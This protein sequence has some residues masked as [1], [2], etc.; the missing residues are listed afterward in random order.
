MISRFAELAWADTPL[1]PLTLRRRTDPVLLVDVFEVK[2]G[3][4][5]LMS[6]LFTVAE[7]ELA[8]L[9]LA[10][11]EGDELEVLVGGLGLGYTAKA[12]LSDPRVRGVTVLELLAPVIGWHR[13]GLLPV[14]RDLTSD[15]RTA[16]VQADFFAVMREAPERR[17]DA[18]LLDIDHSP[19]HLLDGQNGGFYTPEGIAGAARH[20]SRRGVLAVW[21][22]DPPDETF[23]ASLAS[24]FAGVRA[25][26]VSFEN[27]LTGGSSANTVYVAQG[28]SPGL[29]A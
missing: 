1:G 20:L 10:V 3:E 9:A 15:P 28:L 6:S 25:S 13:E 22:D 24:V 11:V 19:R 12:A 2:L 16:L 23:V 8:R 5:F 27:P 4:E 18:I 17:W 26:V 29:E 14:S 7:I 21:S